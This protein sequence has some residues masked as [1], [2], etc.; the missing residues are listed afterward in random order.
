ML[1]LV[2]PGQ[3]AQTPGFLTPW[4]E[5]P[6]AADRVAA[7]SD[8]IGLDLA[9]Y[10]TKADAEEIRDSLL[11]VGGNLDPSPG[12]EQ[13]FTKE[14]TWRYT[15]HVPF[16]GAEDQFMSNKRSV[17]LMQ[18]RIRRQPF[19]DLFDGADPN[20]ETGTRPLTADLKMDV[21]T[22]RS[23]VTTSRGSPTLTDSTL[24]R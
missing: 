21:R 13:P 16:I 2:A 11:A 23:S 19:L 3:G 20:A 24:I 8:A 9:H 18:Q 14:M 10:G 5:L 12:S 4:L 7:W 6:G 1:V 17:Y 15:Q 22:S